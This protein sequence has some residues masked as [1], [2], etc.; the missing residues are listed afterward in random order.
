MNNFIVNAPSV[1]E[2]GFI[3]CWYSR[4]VTLCMGQVFHQYIQTFIVLT[5][6]LLR[7]S[8][9]KKSLKKSEK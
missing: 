1:S 2:R 3:A 8:R 5:E 9:R 7:P 4:G 6:K